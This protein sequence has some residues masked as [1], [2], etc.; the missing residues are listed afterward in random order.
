VNS[1]GEVP[2]AATVILFDMINMTNDAQ[3]N[4]STVNNARVGNANFGNTTFDAMEDQREA[5]NQLLAY[6]RT[7]RKQDRVALYVLGN[8]LSVIQDFT[9]DPDRL[10]RAAERLHQKDAAG[11]EVRNVEE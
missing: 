1:S 11:V 10:V 4:L 2:T 9:G 6:L 3:D 5:I 7:I 8:E